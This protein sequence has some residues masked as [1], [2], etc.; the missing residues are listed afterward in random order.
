LKVLIGNDIELAVLGKLLKNN[1]GVA[2][3]KTDGEILIKEDQTG[4]VVQILQE[5]RNI[6]QK[7]WERIMVKN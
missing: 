1:G 6:S 2:A 3:R 5:R 7:G 4:Q